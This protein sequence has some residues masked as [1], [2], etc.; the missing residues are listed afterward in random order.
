MTSPEIVTAGITM[1][2]FQWT[3]D[4]TT[5]DLIAASTNA[6]N[7]ALLARRPDHYRNFTVV[8]I[9]LMALL[10]GIGGGVTRDVIL[11][12]VPGAFMNPA[13]ILLCLVAG[14]VGYQIAFASGQLFREG[15]FQFMTSFSLPWYA[16]SGAMAAE[17][18]HLPVLGVL[19]L[20]VIGPTAGRYYIDVTSGVPPKQFVRGEWFVAIAALTGLVWV[21][22]DAAGLAAWLSA[23]I[24]FVVGFTVRLIAL[25]RGWEEPLAR[26][27]AGVYK[28]SDGRPLLGRKIAGKSQREMRDLGLVV[29]KPATGAPD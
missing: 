16:I 6:L 27:P 24:S 1:G 5:I 11:N 29:D 23:A 22:C 4:F 12:K 14:F 19:A 9:Y 7:G 21:L 17:A 10:G 18:A 20:A 3:G 15:L 13:Y 8:G 25:Y 26:E 28:H 2:D